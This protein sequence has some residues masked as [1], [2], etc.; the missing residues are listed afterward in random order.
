[1]NRSAVAARFALDLQETIRVLFDTYVSPD[2][3][4][5]D[6]NAL[7]SSE[8]YSDYQR[9]LKE[10]AGFDTTL[11][12]TREE[13]LAFW[14]NLYNMTVLQEV[15]TLD[16]ATTVRGVKGF[17]SRKVGRAGGLEYSLDDIEFG[18]LRD[19]ARQAG[20]AWRIWRGWDARRHSAVH[21][22]EPRVCFALTRAS[23]SGPA[24]RYFEAF[25]IEGQLF[26]AAT[27]FINGG[28]I[29]IDS[30]RNL[31]SLSRLFR[32]YSADFGGG[33]EVVRFVADHMQPEDAATVR[34]LA[35][36]MN[37]RYH[38]LADELNSAP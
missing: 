36:S 17:F 2:G 9:Q 29:L 3:M 21:P 24:L 18:I 7:H 25:G 11:I 30:E 8:A 15:G 6:Y 38:S 14:I 31:L 12:E 22:P 23:S 32:D 16:G 34:S 33:Q 10:L 4:A 19:N 26:Q 20:H 13:R 5:V 35:G 1:V 37:I 28:G 27:D